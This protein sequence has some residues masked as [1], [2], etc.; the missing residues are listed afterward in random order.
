ME[1]HREK[2]NTL[3][4]ILWQEYCYNN[5]IDAT[6]NIPSMQTV[7]LIKVWKINS[8]ILTKA[9]NEITRTKYIYPA[10]YF[11]F[12]VMFSLLSFINLTKS[13]PSFSFVLFRPKDP[14][15]CANQ[16]VAI[17]VFC[18]AVL[19]GS[20]WY[21]ALK[22]IVNVSKT[23][24]LEGCNGMWA[25]QEYI[26]VL[27]SKLKDKTN[28]PKSLLVV[29]DKSKEVKLSSDF[30]AAKWYQ[31]FTDRETCYIDKETNR[32]EHDSIPKADFVFIV[33]LPRIIILK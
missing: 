10:F 1:C 32:P 15:L 17:L 8:K 4:K 19:S 2:S 9:I 24:I 29:T 21:K 12:I 16:W 25:Q 33:R 3:A 14:F 26:S 7:P 31:A 20:S 27:L 6:F 23:I 5:S 18:L 28:N 13:P 30:I 22:K 11:V